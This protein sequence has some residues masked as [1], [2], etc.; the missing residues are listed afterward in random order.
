MSDE[1]GR[2]VLTWVPSHEINRLL[3]ADFPRYER[4]ALLADICRINALYAI[5]RAGSGHIG[6]TFSCMDIVCW[7]HLEVLKDGDRY[8]SSKGHDV[9]ALYAVLTALGRL[10]F[11]KLHLLRRLGGLPGHPDIGSTPELFTNTGSLGM[12]VSKGKG[13]ARADRLLQREGRIFVLTGDGELQEGQ[14]WEALASAVNERMVNLT[15]IIDH[16]KIQSDTWVAKVSDLGDLEA[17]LSAFGW[18]VLRGNG[19]DMGAFAEMVDAALE[20]EAGPTAI[21]ADTVKGAGVEPFAPR[22]EGLYGFHSGA[23]AEDVYRAAVNEL[24]QRCNERLSAEGLNELALQVSEREEI[25]VSP[26]EG[27]RLIAA[28]GDA[29]LKLGEANPDVVAL[30]ADLIL[31]CGL[32]PFAERFPDRFVECGIAEQDM[33]SQAGTM[34]LSGL[35][36]LV[37][38]FASFLSTRPNEQ[39]FNNATEGTKIIYVGS[40]A[41]IVPGGPGHSH[42]SVRDISLFASVPGMSLIEPCSEIQ[43]GLALEWA[44]SEATGPVYIRLVSVPWVVPKAVDSLDPGRGSILRSGGDLVLVGAGP[45]LVGEALAAAELLERDGIVVSVVALPWLRGID[46]N[47]MSEVS[48]DAPILCLDNHVLEGGQGDGVVHALMDAGADVGRVHR[49]A[50]DGIPACGRNDEV[51]RHHGLDAS[52]I[53]MTSRKIV[54]DLA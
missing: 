24:A 39:I 34:A 41:G 22:Q 5:A 33:V 32:I 11:E 17:K 21:V 13:F 23:P 35:L 26:P 7:L 30:D 44:V 8:F 14:F 46:G 47:W 45:V 29:L 37:H 6:T 18:R 28:H 52:G 19:N 16:N 4:A 43:V 27:E 10:P 3:R 36:P 31:D 2:S 12:G 38:S 40:L 42:Q 15:V 54:A 48:G 25:L 1:Y 51:L 53:A 49:L 9:P 50:V 20:E